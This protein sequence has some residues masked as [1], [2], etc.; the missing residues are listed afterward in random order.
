MMKKLIILSFLLSYMGINAQAQNSVPVTPD[1]L[2][3]FFECIDCEKSY[4]INQLPF[5]DF[6]RDAK[7]SD[8][9]LYVTKQKNA[10]EGFRY[11][12]N[13]VGKGNF[14]D[15]NF[16]LQTDSPESDS[17][18][19]RNNRI[20]KTLKFGLTPYISRTKAADRIDFVCNDSLKK[21]DKELKDPWDFWVFVL[22][23]GGSLDA[24]YSNYEYELNGRLNCKRITD[25]WKHRFVFDYEYENETYD[26]RINDMKQSIKKRFI[27]HTRSVYAINRHWSAQYSAAIKQDTYYNYDFYWDLGPGIEYN[28]FPW[29]KSDRKVFALRYEIK[30][31][32]YDYIQPT[33]NNLNS[34]LIWNHFIY[35]ELILRQP[36]GDIESGIKYTSYISDL[37]MYS[38][39][40]ET[41]LSVKL[42]RGFS[43]F[44][45]GDAAIINDQ[46]YLPRGT[47]SLSDRLLQA[48]KEETPFEISGKIG[49]RYSF[50][51]IYNSVVNHRF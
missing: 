10:S 18:L 28:F 34:D 15:I 23:M 27:F 5:V 11:Y 40:L 44:L 48:R 24:E 1:K 47:S 43:I 9:H 6:V 8:L 25:T 31:R 20:L 36:W 46:H 16:K 30:A 4:F 29:D 7:D 42:G 17:G 49:V 39:S 26:Y 33:V 45:R 21:I 14:S 22:D 37:D 19:K 12:L 32:Y 50:G 2:K 3:L 13:F 51:S 38:L 35:A 41:Q